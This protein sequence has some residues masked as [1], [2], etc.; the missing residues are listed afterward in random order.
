MQ[1]LFTD[2]ELKL[3]SKHLTAFAN[4]ISSLSKEEAGDPPFGG[5]SDLNIAFFMWQLGR[6]EMRSKA[7]EICRESQADIEADMIEELL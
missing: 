4:T 2:E 5:Q 6:E 1:K 7:V 3:F